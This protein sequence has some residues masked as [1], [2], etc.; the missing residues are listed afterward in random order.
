[1]E[2]DSLV[3]QTTFEDCKRYLHAEVRRYCCKA[4]I[5]RDWQEVES[6]IFLEFM[7]AYEK[8][9]GLKGEFIPTLLLKIRWRLQENL[10]EMIR[11]KKVRKENQEDPVN[12]PSPEPADHSFAEVIN[13]F[14]EDAKEVIKLV[15]HYAPEH[16][17]HN[18][19]P[20][21]R[22]IKKEVKKALAERGWLRS[23]IMESF[24]EIRE[25]LS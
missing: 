14:S 3:M 12:I 11:K 21:K 16:I 15:L 17:R 9:N 25:A 4:T 6:D 18:G 20:M 5:K 19:K 10:R 8:F 22:E 1:M 23:R 13:L 7:H 24:Q 2:I